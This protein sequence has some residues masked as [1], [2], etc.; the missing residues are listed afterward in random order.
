METSSRVNLT[1]LEEMDEGV[2]TVTKSTSEVD[3][4]EAEFK[5]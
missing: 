5:D 4:S 1:L 3:Q 2:A